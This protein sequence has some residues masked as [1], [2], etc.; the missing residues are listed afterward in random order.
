MM[1]LWHVAFLGFLII[2]RVFRIV[3]D[4]SVLMPA[5]TVLLFLVLSVT[6]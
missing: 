5:A 1:T 6:L 2:S 3:I 4:M